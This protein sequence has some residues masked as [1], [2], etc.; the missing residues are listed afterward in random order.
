M[1]NSDLDKWLLNNQTMLERY[2]THRGIAR[3]YSIV[4]YREL[5]LND[6]KAK[7]KLMASTGFLVKLSNKKYLVSC[8]NVI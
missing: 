1:Y 6:L 4:L 7:F 8:L 3:L 2:K 5:E